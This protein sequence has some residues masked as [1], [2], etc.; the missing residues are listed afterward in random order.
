MSVRVAAFIQAR[1]SSKRLPGKV[2]KSIG[3]RSMLA[4]VVGRAQRAAQVDQVCVL[5][6]VDPSDD[7]IEA[8]CERL[9]VRCIR[10]ALDDVLG[11]FETAARAVEPEI[12]V[13]LTADCP[14]LDPEV[15]DDVVQRMVADDGLA[16]AATRMPDY[17]TFPIGV[18]VEVFRRAGLAKAAVE[19]TE[20]YQR[21]HVTPWF[22]DGSSNG[23]VEHVTSEV[24][25]GTD[26]WTVDTEADL[27]LMRALAT[28]IDFERI[29][30][31]DLAR[32]LDSRP[33]LRDINAHVAQRGYRETEAKP[34]NSSPGPPPTTTSKDAD[35]IN[36]YSKPSAPLLSLKAA[37][38]E[39]N[40]RILASVRDINRL[41]V[42]QPRRTACKNCD[43]PLGERE[44]TKHGVDYATCPRCGHLNGLHEDTPEFC[45][46]VYTGEGDDSYARAY[47][48]EDAAAFRKRVET[49][50]VPKA[51]FLLDALTQLGEKPESLTYADLGAGSGYMVGAMMETGIEAISGFDVSR[52]QVALGNSVL[53]GQP[54]TAHDLDD[55]ADIARNHPA[56]VVSL[57]GVLEH[58][59]NPR[60]ILA[61][62]RENP[63][64]RYVYCSVPLY[65]PSVFL[66]M[67]F[68]EVMPRHLAA[69]HTHLYT[70]ASLAWMA[71]EFGMERV[72]AWWFGSDMM[73]LYRS[74]AVT[75]A[76]NPETSGMVGPWNQMF[77][78]IIDA[79]QAAIDER[80]L[81]SE[82]HMLLRFAD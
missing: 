51:E 14:L 73:D 48:A 72:A 36:R 39:S 30:Y 18:D 57:I 60:E 22:Y 70:D 74:V 40:D 35:V 68:P 69:A 19:A 17:R 62:L 32:F 54:L 41:Y 80:H 38:F 61:S 71:E 3:T 26:R 63:R 24:D 8:E 28:E 81:A 21:E 7:P 20:P 45:A 1:M 11:R 52:V 10:G 43:G 23:R 58:L 59:R 78:P 13:R 47:S 77:G 25:L 53:P 82:V 37:F 9:G 15:V 66:E 65:S 2:L 75:L 76:G 16:Y 67:V 31:L 33:D 29:G 56:D 5:T 46:A 12:I 27:A 55:T 44:F 6:S 79:A 49:I 34:S 64:V 42:A 50:Y 4:H